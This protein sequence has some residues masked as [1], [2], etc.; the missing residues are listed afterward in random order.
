MKKL[1]SLTLTAAACLVLTACSGGGK[2]SNI[3]AP[4]TEN[5]EASQ[6]A[7]PK[8]PETKQPETK[9]P[10][11]KQPETKQPTTQS[12]ATGGV[13]TVNHGFRTYGGQVK[14]VQQKTVLKD[15][16][17]K[18]MVVDG[19]EIP[20]QAGSDRYNYWVC[21]GIDGAYRHTTFGLTSGDKLNYFFYNGTP[22]VTMPTTGKMQYEGSAVMDANESTYGNFDAIP[23]VGGSTFLTADF[24][25]KTVT[26]HMQFSNVNGKPVAPVYVDAKISGNSFNGAA[27][28]QS[29]DT[30]AN[31]EGKFYG[32]D[33]KEVSGMFVDHRN[34]WG[35]AFGAKAD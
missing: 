14:S 23:H 13:Y 16:N 18:V 2:G 21:C 32:P 11:T 20:I 17:R 28:S 9:Q 6:P 12:T 22:T 27:R 26:G 30:S 5:K 33:A 31:L 10:E 34:T 3:N 15:P 19:L 25:N 1:M 8:Q 24:D 7:Q 35:G 29:F 4:G